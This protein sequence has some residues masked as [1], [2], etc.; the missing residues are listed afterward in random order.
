MLKFPLIDVT[1][2]LPK[3]K[4]VNDLLKINLWL[5]CLN[6]ACNEDHHFA[7]VEYRHT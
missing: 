2:T 6:Q 7:H 3:T 4:T 1:P 5:R